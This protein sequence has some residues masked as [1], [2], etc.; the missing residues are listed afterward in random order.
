MSKKW[1]IREGERWVEE[2]IVSREQLGR[3]VALYDSKDRSIGMLPLLG[4]FLLGLGILSFVAANWQDLPNG[5]RL[6]L[7]LVVMLGFYT[8]GGRLIG[9][10]HDHAGIALVSVG[11][12]AFGGGMILIGQM[13]HLVAY[14]AATIVIWSAAG[15]ALAYLFNSRYL[16]IV[17]AALTIAAQIYS[18][19]AF[20]GSFSYTALAVLLL[21]LAWFVRKQADAWITALWSLALVVHALMLVLSNEWPFGWFFVPLLLLY[22][23]GDLLPS[24]IERLALQTPPLAAAFG[25]GL[26]MAL[27][28]WDDSASWV[29]RLH[30]PA[31]FYLPLFLIFLLLSG[32]LKQRRRDPSSFA[33]WLLFLPLLYAPPR[34]VALMY[35]AVLFLFSLYVL[36]R[37]Y[38]E[39]SRRGI[40]LGTLLF[41]VTTMAAYFKLTWAFMDKSLFFLVGGTL[42]LTLSWLLDRRKRHTLH[43][44]KED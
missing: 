35:L 21:G 5:F 8:A 34:S 14:S 1:L 44:A 4:G 28:T 19:S 29:A 33:D 15:V 27:L 43:Q 31:A 32:Y 41:L 10:G 23:A 13:F 39:E 12:F 30:A 24:R 37:G 20:G 26:V 42:L 25:F 17:A 16:F 7:L 38:A 22:V 36:L 9:R 2:E 11:L 40:N 18:L 3:I 6:I